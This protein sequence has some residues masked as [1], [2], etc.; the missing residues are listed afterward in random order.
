ML[1][2]LWLLS[3]LSAF[4]D[5]DDEDDGMQLLTLQWWHGHSWVPLLLL[6]L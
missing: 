4:G 5:N 6:I 2:L 3:W 1:S